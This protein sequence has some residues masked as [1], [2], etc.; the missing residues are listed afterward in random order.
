MI[1]SAELM[2]IRG[3]TAMESFTCDECYNMRQPHIDICPK[4][5]MKTYISRVS[6]W[7]AVSECANCHW[8]VASA[9]GF[10]QTCH[11]D[12]ELYYLRIS[13]LDSNAQMIKL[14]KILSINAISLKSEFD[15]GYIERKH[16]VMDCYRLVK[17]VQNLD[18]KYELDPRI[19]ERYGRLF[20]CE[21]N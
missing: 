8:G 11:A 10:P 15:T 5:G 17:Q 13:K 7:S 19:K 20:T 14:A 12:D 2:V 3:Y 16:K 18:I 4:C 1:L 6:G 21:F 9:G